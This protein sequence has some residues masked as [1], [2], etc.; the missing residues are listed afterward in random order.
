VQ[1]FFV[2]VSR[3]E[4]VLR[5]AYT[6]SDLPC[7]FLGNFLFSYRKPVIVQT[8]RSAVS[9]PGHFISPGI[10]M[11]SIH[12]QAM[13][14]VRQQVLSRLLSHFTQTQRAALQLLIQRLIVMA[15]GPGRLER[16]TIMLTCGGGKDSLLALAFLRAAQLSIGQRIAQTFKLR[17]ATCR[18]AGLTPAAFA[19]VQRAC[20]ALFLQ[21]DPRVELLLVDESG[22]LPLVGHELPAPPARATYRMNLLMSGHLT[23]GDER[24]TFGNSAYLALVDFYQRTLAWNGG[25]DAVAIAGP[26]RELRHYLAW[27]LRGARQYDAQRPLVGDLLQSLEYLSDA[28]YRQIHS[29]L[30]MPGNAARARQVEGC[31]ATELLAL[32]ALLDGNSAEHWPLLVK[33]LGFEFLGQGT[34]FSELDCVSPLLLAHLQG[35]RSE[36]LK[37]RDYRRGVHDYLRLAVPR[38]R[39]KGTP[40]AMIRSTLGA[41]HGNAS[42]QQRR[43][44]ANQQVQATYDLDEGQLVCLL[45]APFVDRG[46]GLMAYLRRCHPAMLNE[47]HGLHAAL[48]GRPCGFRLRQWLKQVSGL[49]EVALQRLYQLRQ[50]D[51]DGDR[52]LIASLRASDPERLRFRQLDPLSG[53]AIR[54]LIASGQ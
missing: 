19:N 38:M 51:L 49:P 36:F 21:D 29:D 31:R 47:L 7:P 32:H 13:G 1:P 42:L 37:E 39:S 41:W 30:H 18:H 24:V 3:V 40:E 12:H 6:G 17:I 52:S 5:R 14:H 50:I 27:G 15:G 23:A 25:A 35:L 11:S 8:L 22:V 9:W 43:Q 54:S 26:P 46:A 16:Y 44:Q 2:A 34:G 28:Y 53:H 20:V 4:R 33:F 10:A 45:F 48:Q